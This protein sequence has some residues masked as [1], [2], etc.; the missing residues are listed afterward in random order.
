MAVQ[1]MNKCKHCGT[2]PVVSD[3]GGCN[4]YYEIYC[5]CGK[6]PVIGSHNKDEAINTWNDLNI[7]GVDNG[8]KKNVH[9]KNS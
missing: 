5:P 6:N 7:G 4:P 1:T 8:R 2:V 3:V 9:R